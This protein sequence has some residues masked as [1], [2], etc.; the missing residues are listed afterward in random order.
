MDDGLQP[1]ESTQATQDSTTVAEP[2]Q[3]PLFFGPDGLRPFWSLLI[4]LLILV[5]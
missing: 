2:P 1:T 3:N 5:Q 4:Y